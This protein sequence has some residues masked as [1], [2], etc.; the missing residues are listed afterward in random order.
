MVN[1]VVE[2]IIEDKRQFSHSS[3]FL[4]LFRDGIALH[5]QQREQK[6][7]VIRIMHEK[8]MLK[9]KNV[10]DKNKKVRL[11]I[12]LLNVDHKYPLLMRWLDYSS[13]CIVSKSFN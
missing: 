2:I 8:L 9:N 13:K 6:N 3:C 4:V 5:S 7:L 10:S 11:K 1:T 12:Y